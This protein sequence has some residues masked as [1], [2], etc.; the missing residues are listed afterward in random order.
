MFFNLI[1][2]LFLSELYE[3]AVQLYRIIDLKKTLSFEYV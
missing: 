2:I 1:S 3:L